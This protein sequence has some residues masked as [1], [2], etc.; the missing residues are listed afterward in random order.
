MSTA[1]SAAYPSQRSLAGQIF[2]P[3]ISPRTYLRAIHLLLMFPL[4]VGYFVFFV[5]AFAFGGSLVWTLIGPPVLLLTMAVSLLLGDLEAWLVRIATGS[6]IRRPPKL[7]EGVTS[8]R[9]KVWARAIDPSTWTGLV[10]EFAQFP[11]GIAGFVLVVTGFTVAGSFIASPLIVWLTNEPLVA[12]DAFTLAIDRPIEALPLVPLGFVMLLVTIH[13]VTVFS[14]LHAAW[15]RLMLGSRGHRA[16]ATE[17]NEGQPP[18]TPD[19]PIAL[20]A[21]VEPVIESLD[22]DNNEGDV[23]PEPDG[24]TELT[25]T[26][27]GDE[28]PSLQL[29]TARERE[30]T[31]LIAR[32]YSNADI[33]E[34]CFIS[35]GTVKTHVGNILSKLELRDRT[36]V[37]VFAYEAGLVQPGAWR[38]QVA[39]RYEAESAVL[40]SARR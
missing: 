21:P 34:T 39:A 8:F 20:L 2:R 1:F 15:A 35:E 31:L 25:P 38:N 36:Q 19:A 26:R 30:L 12:E 7:L 16:P 29:L 23:A 40:Q 14:A 28:H 32:G 18:T 37:V 5:T 17:D 27:T 3:V 11:I 24:L 13:A 6:A 9:Q 4:G 22:G 10:Y 33:G